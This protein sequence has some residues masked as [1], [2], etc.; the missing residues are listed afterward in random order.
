MMYTN[1]DLSKEVLLKQKKHAVKKIY[2]NICNSLMTL[3]ELNEM[4]MS[5][6]DECSGIVLA[7]MQTK[8]SEV[9]KNDD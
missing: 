1:E 4:D 2:T 8:L 9:D 3:A 7:N 6:V 5:Q